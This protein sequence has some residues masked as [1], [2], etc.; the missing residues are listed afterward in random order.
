MNI[1]L[2]SN[3]YP[4]ASNPSYG[5]FVKNQ[6]E[7]LKSES[8][9]ID[10]QVIH[11]RKTKLTKIITYIYHYIMIIIK[12]IYKKY[13]FIYVHYV[14]LNALPILLG[15]FFRK[16]KIVANIHG[17]D[18]ITKNI[19]QEI[20]DK[21]TSKLLNKSSAI[22]VPSSYYKNFTSEKYKLPKQKFFVSPSAGINPQIFHPIKNNI[23][24]NKF[25]GYVGR[26]EA[27]KG[28]EY[29]LIAFKEICEKNSYN[30]LTLFLVGDGTESSKRDK[31]IKKLN[32]EDNVVVKPFTTQTELA[33]IYNK[34]D[35]LVFPS[36]RESL[37]LVGLEAM[38]C[39]TPVIGS[40]IGGIR[41]YLVDGVNGFLSV[42]KSSQSIAENIE[43]FYSLDNCEKKKM[44][45]EAFK[46]A[47]RY[48]DSKVKE[49]F[50]EIINNHIMN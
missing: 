29:L 1:L 33:Y 40:D 37:G 41:T 16:Q 2:I 32:L 34:I 21:F 14:S 38:A 50:M 45:K 7:L 46:T 27:D 6:A 49:K 23:I 42:P 36:L 35:V 19:G 39:G 48:S 12:I 4:D 24:N 30:N 20:I 47:E 43:K 3:M 13:D 5:V 15:T 10:F 44:S 22:I 28:W 31:L 9:S 8:I 11:K 18:I 26:V 17:S 25:I